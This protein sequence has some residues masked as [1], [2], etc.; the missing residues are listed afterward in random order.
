MRQQI[1]HDEKMERCRFNLA[2]QL[3]ALLDHIGAQD[4]DAMWVLQAVHSLATA[5]R[6]CA[7]P[8]LLLSRS[9]NKQQAALWRQFG[10]SGTQAD[11]CATGGADPHTDTLWTCPP[12]VSTAN[13]KTWNVPP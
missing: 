5:T 11:S 9:G 7:F 12:R 10:S 13:C 4:L 8:S 1:R 2:H 6:R 3:L